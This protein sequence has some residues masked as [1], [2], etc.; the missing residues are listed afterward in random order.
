MGIGR[1]G[2]FLRK[3][4]DENPYNTFLDDNFCLY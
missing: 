1:M 3:R 2:S 4:V